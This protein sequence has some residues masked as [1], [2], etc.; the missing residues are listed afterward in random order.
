MA[1]LPL[2]HYQGTIAYKELASNTK[3][4]TMVAMK[5][6]SFRCGPDDAGRRFDRILAALIAPYPVSVAYKLIRTGRALLNGLKPKASDR[7]AEGDIVSI[8]AWVSEPRDRSRDLQMPPSSGEG[9]PLRAPIIFEARDLLFLDKP[10][11]LLS[12][13]KGSLC[14]DVRHY[15]ADRSRHSIAFKPSPLNRLDRATRGIICYGTGYRGAAAFAALLRDGKIEKRYLAV[16]IGE[17][18]D[19]SGVWIDHI[20]RDRDRKLSFITGDGGS[21]ARLSWKRVCASA[22]LSLLD[23]HLETG[24]THQIRCQAASRN[25]PLAGDRKYGSPAMPSAWGFENFYLRAYLMRSPVWGDF[26]GRERILALPSAQEIDA[27]SR[28]FRQ[29]I[30][31]CL[32]RLT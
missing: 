21:E 29:P 30:G 15:A 4:Y 2:I 10:S 16:L 18:E 17:I 32:A 13:G 9:T 26:V 20:D 27:L 19:A 8:K 22:G 31:E 11:G 12:H 24:L 28:A 25:H 7:V 1:F 5:Q 14:E 3:R 23:I 6:S